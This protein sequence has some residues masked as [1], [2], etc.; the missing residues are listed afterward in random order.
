[1]FAYQ[2]F[3]LDS[4]SPTEC[5]KTILPYRWRVPTFDLSNCYPTGS[6]YIY[7]PAVRSVKTFSED[8][9]DYDIVCPSNMWPRVVARFRGYNISESELYDDIDPFTE[10]VM[11]IPFL[12]SKVQIALIKPK[13]YYM[14][15][16]AIELLKQN[17]DIAKMYYETEKEGRGEIWRY[18]YHLINA[19]N[20]ELKLGGS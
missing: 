14:K 18:M 19:Y 7:H 3:L 6:R 16:Q 20:P 15:L 11:T 17:Q 10:Q 13:A 2:A 8:A 5:L 12:L 4:E 1:M 9:S